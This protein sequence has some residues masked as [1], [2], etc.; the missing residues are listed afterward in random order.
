MGLCLQPSEP[1]HTVKLRSRLDFAICIPG[2]IYFKLNYHIERERAKI[3][4]KKIFLPVTTSLC[5]TSA[6]PS[7]FHQT[8][9]YKLNS[10]LW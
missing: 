10:R 2:R 8:F 1:T 5:G 3:D 4:Q 9:G 7:F 6:A